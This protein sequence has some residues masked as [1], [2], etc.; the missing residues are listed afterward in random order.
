MPCPFPPHPPAPSPLVTLPPTRCA[1]AER[2]EEVLRRQGAALDPPLRRGPLRSLARR[3]RAGF[4]PGG[5]VKRRV[6]VARGRGCAPTRGRGRC[7]P[8]PANKKA[9][10]VAR[11]RGW[12]IERATEGAVNYARSTLRHLP[13]TA[14]LHP[15]RAAKPRPAG[16]RRPAAHRT[17]HLRRTAGAVQVG[18]VQVGAGGR[19]RAVSLKTGRGA[20]RASGSSTMLRVFARPTLRKRAPVVSPSQPQ[21]MKTPAL[22]VA[23]FRAQHEALSLSPSRAGRESLL[24]SSTGR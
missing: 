1:R 24:E 5:C 21:G 23:R 13:R 12:E 19:A 14:H 7:T 11:R 9:P 3:P 4:A 8:F 18:A 10:G 6:G 15:V 22:A 17:P 16:A 20:R 2:G